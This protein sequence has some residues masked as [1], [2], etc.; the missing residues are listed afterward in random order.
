MTASE[1]PSLEERLSALTENYSARLERDPHEAMPLS[2]V[3][4]DLSLLLQGA[5]PDFDPER[6]W[7]AEERLVAPC[8]KSD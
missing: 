4:Q 1:W 6:L 3:V 7:P 8:K 5:A 2:E